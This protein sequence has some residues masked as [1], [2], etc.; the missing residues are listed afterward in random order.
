MHHLLHFLWLLMK[1]QMVAFY[2]FRY[3]SGWGKVIPYKYQLDWI[4]KRAI[5]LNPTCVDKIMV[6][7]ACLHLSTST[8]S[9]KQE[10]L[11]GILGFWHHERSSL[12]CAGPVLGYIRYIQLTFW[13]RYPAKICGCRYSL[14]D[15][16]SVCLSPPPPLTHHLQ[17]LMSPPPVLNIFT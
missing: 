6:M 7:E 1:C 8:S 14:L 3:F 13:C 12:A 10:I 17:L 11:N 9:K 4:I 2:T 15:I 5:N 16:S